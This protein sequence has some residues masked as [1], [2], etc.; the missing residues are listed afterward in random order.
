[1]AAPVGVLAGAVTSLCSCSSSS[2]SLSS[3]SSCLR[4][5]S[6]SECLLLQFCHRDRY[7]QCQTV[8]RTVLPSLQYLVRLVAPVVQRQVLGAE[9]CRFSTGAVLGGCPL[10]SEVAG[11][12]DS[13]YSS[14][15]DYPDY[16]D[17]TDNT[18]YRDNPDFPHYLSR[19]SWTRRNEMHSFPKFNLLCAVR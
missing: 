14:H 9:N 3:S 8:Q 13:N 11:S 2:S 17:N 16:R 4:F 12:P 5:S 6:S 7:A 19:T 15:P 18:D 10:T 1:M